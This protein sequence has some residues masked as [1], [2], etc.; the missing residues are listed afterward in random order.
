MKCPM[1]KSYIF[2]LTMLPG[3]RWPAET[4]ISTLS[5]M[6]RQWLGLFEKI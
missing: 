6:D 5:K 1:C 2:V 4:G 3:S